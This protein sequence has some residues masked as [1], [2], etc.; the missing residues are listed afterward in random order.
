VGKG[1][2][3]VELRANASKEGSEEYKIGISRRGGKSYHKEVNCEWGDAER[4]TGKSEGVLGGE[5]KG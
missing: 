4:S 5:V 2:A 3:N 1:T